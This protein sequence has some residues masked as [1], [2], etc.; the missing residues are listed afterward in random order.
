MAIIQQKHL[1]CDLNEPIFHKFIINYNIKEVLKETC[2]MKKKGI[3]NND[4]FSFLMK[5]PFTGKSLHQN[6]IMNDD[7]KKDTAYRF[8]QDSTGWDDAIM[9]IGGSIINKT[10][11]PLTSESRVGCLIFDDTPIER[12][13][14]KKVELAS[15]QFNHAQHKFTNGFR[16]LT[17]AWSDGNTFI[18]LS[19][20]L[21][22]SKKEKNRTSEAY[23]YDKTTE[24]GK[25]TREEAL[26]TT[27]ELVIKMLKQSKANHI[28]ANYV[29]FDSWFAMPA[30]INSIKAIGYDVIAM[31]KK[32]DKIH[33]I[34][35]DESKSVKKIYKEA[36]KRR[37][38][39]HIRYSTIA[40]TKPNQDTTP[41]KVKLVYISEKKKPKNWLIL[42]STD[43]SL[44]DER[45]CQ[46]YGRRWSTEVFY[47][48]CKSVLNL[49]RG[50]QC[51]NFDSIVSHIAI[52][53]IQYMMLSEQQR[54]FND[55]RTLGELFFYMVDELQELTVAATIA[56]VID[57]LIETVQNNVKLQGALGLELLK[58]FI[59]NLP[60]DLVKHLKFPVE[61]T[62]ET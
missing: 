40:E 55:D 16:L 9:K 2:K 22:S 49:Q 31:V 4:I 8:L 44:D 33:F 13:R 17:M 28:D 15:K 37:G 12:A 27:P 58:D 7:F 62:C 30:T 20:A 50:C 5:I 25:R 46:L 42:V 19:F 23:N 52:V 45:V 11:N 41:V 1:N 56:L 54:L 10:I 61:F 47:K 26:M 18:P 38:L 6:V 32:S 43:T 35:D 29:L 21:L 53:F 51:R 3:S 36:T 14:S 60:Q 48:V 34:K 24:K 59:T 57:S 39:A